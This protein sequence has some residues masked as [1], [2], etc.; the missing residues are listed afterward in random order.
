MTLG[1]AGFGDRSAL[2]GRPGLACS[3]ALHVLV[4]VPLVVAI[5]SVLETRPPPSLIPIE[6]IS[7][8]GAD[9]GVPSRK[10]EAE[11]TSDTAPALPETPAESTENE[12][13]APPEQAMARLPPAPDRSPAALAAPDPTA[14]GA[15]SPNPTRPRLP[16]KPRQASEP[17]HTSPPPATARPSSLREPRQGS[18]IAEREPDAPPDAGGPTTGSS[19]IRTVKDFLRFQIVRRWRPQPAAA[20]TADYAVSI[21]IALNRDGSVSRAEIVEDPRYAADPAYRAL[22]DSARRAVLLASP[23]SLPDGSY[24]EVQDFVLDL[25]RPVPPS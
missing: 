11:A 22:A 8:G 25:G 20:R 2:V 18:P 5:S 9:T 1:S 14:P 4:A 13:S 12:S 16:P 21:H 24:D 7:L 23:L 3:L 15:S 10:A 19:P 17:S 6:L